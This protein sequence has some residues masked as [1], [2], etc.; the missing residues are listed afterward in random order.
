MIAHYHNQYADKWDADQELLAIERQLASS[1]HALLAVSRSVREHV[2]NYIAV[3]EARIDVVANGVDR[4]IL[5]GADRTQARAALGI[6]PDAFAFGLIGRVCHQ[7]GQDIF[8]E[9]AQSLA[10]SMPQAVFV[11][12]GDIEDEALHRRL[13]KRITD[14]GLSH[15]IMFAGYRMDMTNVYAALDAVV[16]P[17]RWEGF[18]L[19]LVEAM[20][21]R[22][23]IVAASVGAIPE[24]TGEGKAAFLVPPGDAPALAVAMAKLAED[25]LLQHSLVAAGDERQRHFTWDACTSSVAAI[26]RRVLEAR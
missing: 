20:A 15:A 9:A 11:M 7:K 23:P 12:V 4:K 2:S 6:A 16:A 26:Y 5:Q 17:S 13:A 3:P 22:K 21:A 24:V 25:V 8:V 10:A 1:T 18:G 14:A 19:M